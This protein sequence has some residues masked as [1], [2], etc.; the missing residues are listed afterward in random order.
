[1]LVFLIIAVPCPSEGVIATYGDPERI[2]RQT[3]LIEVERAKLDLAFDF[4]AFNEWGPLTQLAAL[5]SELEHRHRASPA[6]QAQVDPAIDGHLLASLLR[7]SQIIDPENQCGGLDLLLPCTE[8]GVLANFA[9]FFSAYIL[10]SYG[11]QIL[12]SR[13]TRDAALSFYTD[14][15]WPQKIALLHNQTVPLIGMRLLGG[16][17]PPRVLRRL[18]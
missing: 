8:N 9:G 7:L 14:P 13:A 4:S 12:W 16:D 2:A 15:N 1:M 6:E 18:V 5:M 10:K 11:N 3:P 17:E